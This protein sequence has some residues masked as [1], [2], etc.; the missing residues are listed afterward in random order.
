MCQIVNIYSGHTSCMCVFPD[1]YMC[2]DIYVWYHICAKMYTYMHDVNMHICVFCAHTCHK[3]HV[4]MHDINTSM[5]AFPSLTRVIH[6]YFR[7]NIHVLHGFK[8]QELIV[9]N[10]LLMFCY[11]QMRR[12]SQAGTSHFAISK[13]NAYYITSGRPVDTC[14]PY[15]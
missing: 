2:T 12:Q 1:T 8:V 10:F 11:I 4:Y 7:A 14:W 9:G 5:C 13:L 15:I 6:L 3:M